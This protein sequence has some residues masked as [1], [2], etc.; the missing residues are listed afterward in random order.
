M[1]KTAHINRRTFLKRSATAMGA[2]G[3]VMQGA[4]TSAAVPAGDPNPPKPNIIFAMTDDQGYGDLGYMGHEHL[5]TPVLDEMAQQGLRLDRFYAHP[6]CSPTRASV[7][8][9]R[10]SNRSGVFTYGN[11]LRDQEHTVATALREA[12][13]RTGTFGKWHL[14]SVRAG[15]PTSPDG[16]GFDVWSAAANFYENDPWFS[17]NGE[18]VQVHGESSAV[19]VEEALPFIRETVD[20]GKPFFAMVWFGAP[21]TPHE[22]TEEL[23]ELY[24][25]LPDQLRNYY[26][27]LTGVDRAMGMLRD[28]LRELGIEQNTLLIFTSDNG[29]RPQDGAEHRG[30]RGNKGQVWEGGIRVPAVFE[31]P[32]RIEPRISQTPANTVDLYPTFLELAGVEQPHQRPMDGLSLVPLLEGRMQTRPKPLGFWE[33][34]ERSGQGMASDEILQNLHEQQQAGEPPDVNE[35]RIYGPDL[36]Y[37]EADERPGHAAW[38]DNEWKLHRLPNGEHQ[39]F[40]LVDDK[41]EQNNLIEQHPDV[42]ERMQRQ[43][44]E[45]EQS[46][47]NSMRGA[48]Y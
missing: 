5:Q 1:K 18:A 29:G 4:M 21:H 47:I 37:E 39:L 42:A 9:G 7:L 12:G 19:T 43:L 14:G 32:S 2:A 25:E 31:W 33:Y 11:A 35:G 22:A 10:H 28:E 44:R 34:M 41:G 38:M 6:R 16:H 30:L 3:A 46:V 23:Q 24:S 45:W 40:H 36:D 27:E 8:T 13:Y 48:D 15:Q 17:R 20:E 26:G